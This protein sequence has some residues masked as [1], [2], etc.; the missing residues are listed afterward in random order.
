MGQDI[1][2]WRISRA[3][4]RIL[5]LVGFGVWTK[6]EALRFCDEYRSVVGGFEGQSWAILGDATNWVL[7]NPQVQNLIRDQNRWIVTAGCRA[8]S[9]YTGPGALNRLLLYRLAEPD[10][11][12]FHFR[13]HPHRQRAVEA[14]EENGFAVSSTQLNSFFRGEGKRA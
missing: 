6:T 9:F 14:L 5:F 1:A 12:D 7:D 3:G 8:G 13:V 10:S 11:D 4:D 2:G